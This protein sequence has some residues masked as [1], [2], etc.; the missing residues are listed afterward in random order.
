MFVKG[1]SAPRDD[2]DGERR[3]RQGHAPN[4]DRETGVVVAADTGV[5]LLSCKER[6]RRDGGPRSY[7]DFP[8]LFTVSVSLCHLSRYHSLTLSMLIR[9][10]L[11][12]TTTTTTQTTT[13]TNYY[14]YYP[15][16]VS[17]FTFFF[18][19]SFFFSSV[20]RPNIC[21]FLYTRPGSIRKILICIP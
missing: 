4:T 15:T 10:L 17:S 2:T 12:T 18:C 19:F 11:T 8:S 9:L 5:I 1:F 16:P 21:L 14:Y 7:L 3:R 13:I 6:V 20:N